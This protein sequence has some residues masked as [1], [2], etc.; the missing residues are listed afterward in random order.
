MKLPI[1][2]NE[3][4][5]KQGLLGLVVALV[6]LVKDVLS[7]QALRRMEG[8]RLTDEEINR[9]GEALI[10]LSEALE[11]IKMNNDLEKVVRDVRWS[12]DDLV[13][14]VLD[15]MINPERWAEDIQK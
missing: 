9:L 5:L 7:M 4:N 12:L 2:I 14:D 3:D 15:R 13:D 11:Q 1:Q 8:G 6:E 10:D